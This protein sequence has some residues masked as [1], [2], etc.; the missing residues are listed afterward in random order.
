MAHIRN[1][2]KGLELDITPISRWLEEGA[3]E[4]CVEYEIGLY[5]NDIPLFSD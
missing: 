3:Q 2:K 5:Y 1:G 4:P